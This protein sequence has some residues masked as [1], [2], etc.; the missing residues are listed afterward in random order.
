MKSQSYAATYKPE[1][2]HSDLKGLQIK[3]WATFQQTKIKESQSHD[4]SIRCGVSGR[5]ALNKT[6]KVTIHSGDTGMDIR[7]LPK[8]R[9]KQ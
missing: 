3:S 6:N 4:L 7:A 9:V 2:K 8:T 5:Y 1:L